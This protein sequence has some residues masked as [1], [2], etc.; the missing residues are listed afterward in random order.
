M[1]TA[2]FFAAEALRKYDLPGP[3]YTSYPAAPHFGPHFDAAMLREY[4]RCSNAEPIPRELSLYVHVPYCF[5]PCFYCGCTPGLSCLINFSGDVAVRNMRRDGKAWRVGIESCGRIGSAARVVQLSRG[6]LATSGDSR[7]FV[8]RGGNR[9]SH[10]LDART[11]WPVRNALHSITVAADTCT[12]A[13]TL[14]TL[15]MLQGGNAEHLLKS[16]GMQYWLQ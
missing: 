4:I 12:Q 15:A 10:I 5:S 11:G 6:A 3:R 1:Q 16:S 2:P 9:Y 13:G 14:T 8:F 7:R